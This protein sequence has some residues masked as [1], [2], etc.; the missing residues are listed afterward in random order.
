MTANVT[1][2]S[3]KEARLRTY[4][5]P[6]TQSARVKLECV[7]RE[8][9]PRSVL[10]RV[11]GYGREDVPVPTQLNPGAT[12]TSLSRLLLQMY[13]V[14][15]RYVGYDDSRNNMKNRHYISALAW[16]AHT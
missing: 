4:Y 16:R 12:L 9:G 15:D 8:R 2:L 14:R 7:L 11:Y 10:G 1:P 6:Q 13:K 5:H 3:T